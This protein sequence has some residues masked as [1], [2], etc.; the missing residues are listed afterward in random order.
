MTIQ[1][2]WPDCCSEGPHGAIVARDVYYAPDHRYGH[3]PIGALL[4]PF[5]QP[6]RLIGGEDLLGMRFA[7]A[8]FLDTETTGL[9][10]GTG[11]YVFLVGVARFVDGRLLLRQFF[12]RELHEERALLQALNE[13]AAGC[14]GLVTFNG[15][16][17]DLP[18]LNNRHIMQ[19]SRSR[20][21]DDLHLDLLWPA[22]RIWS[23][24]LTSCSLTSLERELLGVARQGDVPGALIPELYFRYLR[25][26]DASPLTAVFEHNRRDVLALA[27]LAGLLCGAALQPVDYIQHPVDLVALGR[28]FLRERDYGQAE[29][30]YDRALA[31]QLPRGERGWAWLGL[32]EVYRRTG[33]GE[34][35]LPLLQVAARQGGPAGLEAAIT[36]AKYLEHRARD[37]DAAAEMTAQALQSAGNQVRQRADLLSRMSR[38]QRKQARAAA[39]ELATH[40]TTGETD[41]VTSS[42]LHPAALA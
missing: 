6:P 32:A 22:R 42:P 21:P 17:F 1:E 14:T 40:H 36:L 26:K 12:L 13:F 3:L 34:T 37:F 7:D 8:L 4:E 29:C 23:R 10:G 15:K 28:L 31:G 33:R 38:L 2:L 39:T 25:G 19:R 41:A 27:A 18:L 24:R 5:A 35:A 9:S 16:A 20:L 30:C 11:T